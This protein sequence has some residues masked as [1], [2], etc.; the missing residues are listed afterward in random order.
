MT[1]QLNVSIIYLSNICGDRLING[2]IGLRI[3]SRLLGL[4]P[5][6]GRVP[7]RRHHNPRQYASED[8]NVRG[9]SG[10]GLTAIRSQS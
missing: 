9:R 5:I 4:W 6:R 7:V 3:D 8:V 2:P 1:M 10:R